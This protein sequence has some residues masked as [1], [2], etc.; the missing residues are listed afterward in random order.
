MNDSSFTVRSQQFVTHTIPHMN[1]RTRETTRNGS[2][3]LRN[4]AGVPTIFAVANEALQGPIV[5]LC[6]ST[7]KDNF[8]TSSAD[9]V[10]HLASGLF[11]RPL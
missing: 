9:K 7:C 11:Y 4:G 6:S 8:L 5:C 3:D 1:N 2:R 10:C